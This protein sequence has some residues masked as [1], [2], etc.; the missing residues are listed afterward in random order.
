PVGYNGRAGTVVV[1]GTPIRRPAG[2]RRGPGGPTFG[3]SE[4]LD[5]ELEVGFVVG[6]PSAIGEPVP[7]GE[8]ERQL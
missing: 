4:R 2:Q 5:F 7:I 6:S 8:A 3:P 1:S